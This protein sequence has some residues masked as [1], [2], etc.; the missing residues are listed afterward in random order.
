MLPPETNVEMG[1]MVS[2]VFPPVMRSK[3]YCVRSSRLVPLPE[4]SHDTSIVPT[5]IVAPAVG[6]VNW[7]SAKTVGKTKASRLAGR[8]RIVGM[9][10][11]LLIIDRAT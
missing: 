6:A 11:A 3:V 10:M 5:G 9:G 1:R 7:T 8:R 2:F 4:S